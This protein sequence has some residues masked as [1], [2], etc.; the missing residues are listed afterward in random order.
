MGKKLAIIGAGPGGYVAALRAASAGADVTLIEKEAVGGTCLNW[1]CI[2]SKIMKHTA[3][4]FEKFH[5]AAAY[6]LAL[7]GSMEPDMPALMNRKQTIIKTQQQG[8]HTLLKKQNVTLI[9]GTASIKDNHRISVRSNGLDDVTV[10]FDSLIIAV[11]TE[12]LMIPGVP[13]DGKRIL[14]SNHLLAL[15]HVP[16]SILIVGGGVIGCEFAFILSSLGSSVTLVEAMD[17][18][19]PL[20]SVDSSCSKLLQREMKKRKIKCIVD[21]AVTG[22]RI[23][24]TGVSATIG[25]SPFAEPGKDSDVQ[26]QELDVEVMAV[27]I[28]RAPL[29][30][31]LHLE[32]LG[33]A[34]DD[35]GWVLVNDRMETNVTDVYAIGDCLGP[36]RIMLAHVASHEGLVAAENCLGGNETM[37]YH[38]VPNAIFTMPEIGCVGLSEQQ[39]EAKGI[40]VVCSTVNFR[41]LGKAQAIG[42]ISGE[43]KLVLEKSTGRILGVHLSGPHATDLIAEGVIAV[44][45]GLTALDLSHTIHAHPTLA[46][47]MSEAAFKAIGKPLHS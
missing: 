27:C 40:E 46:E 10:A 38:A 6:G 17:R 14:S 47:I 18:I 4:L 24:E 1:G 30:R 41:S 2:P 19:L 42:E 39:A 13:F 7:S 43:A 9:K 29:T 3:D 45:Q 26:D 5:S 20:D 34:M 23:H 28:G 16:D 33:V 12:P 21:R 31:G 15:D 44:K 37:D 8:I 11:G 35:R 22:T 25:A 32:T 36:S